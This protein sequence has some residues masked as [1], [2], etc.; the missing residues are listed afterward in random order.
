MPLD[1]A[2]PAG[3][4]TELQYR[5]SATAFGAITGS[6][7]NGTYLT[8]PQTVIRSKLSVGSAATLDGL[9]AL[10]PAYA[11]QITL[12]AQETY[13][14]LSGN[15]IVV[16]WDQLELDPAANNS[17]SCYATVGSAFTKSGNDKNTGL[18]YGGWFEALHHGTGT[19]GQMYGVEA[20]SIADQNAPVTHN[21][22]ME[23]QA[24]GGTNNYG[25]SLVARRRLIYGAVGAGLNYGVSITAFNDQAISSGVDAN[26]GVI[27][28]VTRTGATGGTITSYGYYSE[29]TVDNAGAGSHFS[30]DFYAAARSGTSD[31]DYFLWFGSPGVYRV[32]ADGVMAYYNPAFSPAYT[33]NAVDYERVVQQWNSNV[34]EYG[35]EAGGTGTLRA[36]RLLGSSVSADN[37][38]ATGSTASTGGFQTTVGGRGYGM[39]TAAG[40]YNTIASAGGIVLHPQAASNVFVKGSAANVSRPITFCDSSNNT[41]IELTPSNTLGFALTWVSAANKGLVIR[42]AASQTGQLCQ[43]QGIS[44]TS[45]AREQ[46]EWDTTAIDNTDA[47]R[48]YRSIH[49]A[50]DT[51]AREYMRGW[52]DG[53]NGR[54]ACAAPASA[55]TDAHLAASQISFYLDESG[56]NLLIRAKYADGTTLKLATIALA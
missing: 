17:N 15:N 41:I 23:I 18:V 29:M 10:W 14:D 3:S 30:Y 46:A 34:L 35:V 47:T 22:G 38:I 28:R 21:Y 6:I 37:F 49:R 26:Y 42:G 1:P 7:W 36:M 52:G 45:T 5:S 11:H 54:V 9:T 51:A 25:I 44:S 50:Y 27:S 20:Y 24:Y 39:G 48:K 53:S 31:A 43:L 33:P 32:K 13:T 16:H 8:L 55:P 2:L 19:I 56:H 40:G 12:L 4:A